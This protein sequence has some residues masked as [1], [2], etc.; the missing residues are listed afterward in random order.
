[1][2]TFLLLLAVPAVAN[3]PAVANIPAADSD[4]AVAFVPALPD[5]NNRTGIFLTVVY[6][7]IGLGKLLDYG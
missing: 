1:L 5:Y 6:R 2:L 7:T 4:P 3:S